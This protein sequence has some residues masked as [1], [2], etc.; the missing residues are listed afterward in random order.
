ERNPDAAFAFPAFD[1]LADLRAELNQQVFLEDLRAKKAV[2][3]VDGGSCRRVVDEALV[4]RSPLAKVA[5][6]DDPA[7]RFRSVLNHRG[8]VGEHRP[9]E[10]SHHVAERGPW[11]S[12]REELPCRQLSR[13]HARRNNLSHDLYAVRVNDAHH[14]EVERVDLDS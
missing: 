11:T 8:Q 13:I 10:V 7:V 1:R 5:V 12:I 3:Y 14:E 4:Q 9:L 6:N 2:L